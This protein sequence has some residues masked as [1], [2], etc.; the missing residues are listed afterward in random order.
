MHHCMIK[1]QKHKMETIISVCVYI[2]GKQRF[3]DNTLCYTQWIF[4]HENG[5][6][7]HMILYDIFLL[8]MFDVELHKV[9]QYIWCKYSV[10]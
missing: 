7:R 3:D 1:I 5:C 10:K 6:A 4:G 9:L 2:F 8:F